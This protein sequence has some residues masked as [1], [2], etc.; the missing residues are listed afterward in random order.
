M[1][2]NI[3][4]INQAR[5]IGMFLV[6][7]GHAMHDSFIRGGGYSLI[8]SLIIDFIY[9]FHMPLFFFISGFCSEKILRLDTIHDKLHY[10]SNRAKRLMIPYF[11]IGIIYIPLKVILSDEVTKQINFKTLCFEFLTGTNPNFQLWTLYALFIINLIVCGIVQ[12][13]KKLIFPIACVLCGFSLFFP[14]SFQILNK[15]FYECIFFVCGIYS[16]KL[17]NLKE[18]DIRSKKDNLIKFATIS[19]FLLIGLNV[20]KEI[21]QINQIKIFTAFIGILVVILVS[22]LIE[23]KNNKCLHTI[24]EYGMDIYIMA[25]L[26]QVL[27]RSIFL[28]KLSL[29]GTACCVL[30][31]LLG[32]VCPI[33]V[34]KLF[35]RKFRITRLLILGVDK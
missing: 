23:E 35:V 17:W 9:S 5:G 22:I 7:F 2:K 4:W 34:S 15:S 19:V 21:S 3:E 24:G 30:S 6:V 31:T 25:N 27:C 18:S 11:F 12:I 1:K 8:P 16:R 28:G 29:P 10:V 32:I 14:T 20:I 26:V 13:N 33:I